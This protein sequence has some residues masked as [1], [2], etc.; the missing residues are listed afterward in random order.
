MKSNGKGGRF[1][2]PPEWVG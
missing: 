1:Y 2:Q